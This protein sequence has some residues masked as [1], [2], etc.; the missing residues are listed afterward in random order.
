MRTQKLA[1]PEPVSSGTFTSVQRGVVIALNLV[2]KRPL[3]MTGTQSQCGGHRT[4]GAKDALRSS[5]RQGAR[6]SCAAA[7]PGRL[8]WKEPLEAH[9]SERCSWR[10]HSEVHTH[11]Q[12]EVE[13]A[14]QRWSYPLQELTVHHRGTRRRTHLGFQ[15]RVFVPSCTCGIKA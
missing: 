4:P 11:A 5:A 6:V 15:N 2:S 10:S 13:W 12:C 9:G 7:V 14:S 8:G 1:P 3:S